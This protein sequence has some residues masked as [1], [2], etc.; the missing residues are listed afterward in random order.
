MNRDQIEYAI[1]E[2]AVTATIIGCN[3]A[4]KALTAVGKAVD[5]R[6]GKIAVGGLCAL[7]IV[8]STVVYA[9]EG[10]NGGGSGADEIL[11]T[12][13]DT[14]NNWIPKIGAVIM[15]FGGLKLALAIKDNDEGERTNGMKTIAAGAVVEA[16]A[17][18][19]HFTSGS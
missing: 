17:G 12:L 8:G 3:A 6:A 9:A 4:N 5:T 15:G 10:G 13:E 16:V 7:S 2:K 19:I 14:L 1:P 11:S 18:A